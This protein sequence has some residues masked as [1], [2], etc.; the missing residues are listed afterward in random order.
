MNW[1]TTWKKMSSTF[2]KYINIS[3]YKKWV[4]VKQKWHKNLFLCFLNKMIRMSEFYTK[5]QF[6]KIWIW[7]IQ[8]VENIKTIF[9]T[10]FTIR[11]NIIL[12]NNFITKKSSLYKSTC[13]IQKVITLVVSLYHDI[14]FEMSFL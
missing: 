5:N 7:K 12:H 9:F 1:N 14:L 13:T 11:W 3:T 4:Y 8:I 2:Q 10:Y 6:V